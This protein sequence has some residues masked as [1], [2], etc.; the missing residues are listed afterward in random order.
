MRTRRVMRT[1][2]LLIAVLM[3]GLIA[4]GIAPHRAAAAA[5]LT[6]MSAS[7]SA[8][9]GKRV[10]IRVRISEPAPRGG[11]NIFLTSSNP[12]I[13]VPAYAH[14]NT[15][16]TDELVGITTV[17]VAHTVSVTVTARYGGVTKSK[18][19]VIYEPYI[20][21]VKVPATILA[22]GQGRI[23]VRLGG[24]AP[25]GGLTVSTSSNRPSV[26]PV[27]TTLFVEPGA[28]SA[29]YLATAADVTTNI[30]LTI[31]AKSK[32]ITLTGSTV[33]TYI[34]PEP[35]QTFTITR[36]DGTAPVPVG[37]SATFN[38][39]ISDPPSSSL[40]LYLNVN[41][42]TRASASPTSLTFAPADASL[43]QTG[44][45]VD[46]GGPSSNS[47]YAALELWTGPTRTPAVPGSRLA[48]SESV[49]FP[50]EPVTDTPTPTDTPTVESADE[51]EPTATGTPTPEQTRV[52]DPTETGT[53]APADLGSPTPDASGPATETPQPPAAE[54]PI[55]QSGVGGTPEASAT[56]D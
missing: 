4:G 43:C 33:V 1:I 2:Q 35:T 16:A 54:L 29:S 20:S 9:G 27:P 42:P 25:A 51:S 10:H 13:P 37:G 12:A 30:S 34:P 23:W 49:L 24:R 5:T 45:L 50:P 17:P 56:G 18:V 31:T 19:I 55:E 36:T 21:S 3:V 15:G 52:P 41:N 39:C 47:G 48:I 6:S 46:R 53:Q 38:I 32:G 14:I 8:T 40:K 11:L 26:L 44:Y 28:A 7:G 22:N